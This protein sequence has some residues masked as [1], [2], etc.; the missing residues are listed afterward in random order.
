MKVGVCAIVKN[1]NL[2]LRDWVEYHLGIGF[3][4]VFIYDNNDIEKPEGVVYDY[5]M[6]C[7]VEVIPWKTETLITNTTMNNWMLNQIRAYNHCIQ[8]NQDFDWI[9]FIDADEYINIVDGS[10]IKYIISNNPYY[11][12]Y[13]AIVLS[14]KMM[15][16]PNALYYEN[17]PVRER[18]TKPLEGIYADVPCNELVKSIVNIKSGVLFGEQYDPCNPHCPD[19]QNVC[20]STGYGMGE[21]YGCYNRINW[22]DH[23]IMHVEHYY[24]KSLT[25][26][27]IKSL[28]SNHRYYNDCGVRFDECINQYKSLNGWS[29]EHEKVYQDFLRRH[30]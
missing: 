21:W 30:S 14:W 29:D 11:H 15:G 5:I 24:T 20:I 26:Y 12:M 8:N 9:A 10:P 18:F 25:E 22:P 27:L 13:D 17:K 1:E 28:N 3:D 7:Q 4:K 2:Y 19:T 6:S 16:D 23:R